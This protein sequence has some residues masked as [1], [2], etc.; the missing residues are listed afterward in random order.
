MFSLE[1]R[2]H[3]RLSR[4]A[5]VAGGTFGRRA[6]SGFAECRVSRVAKLAARDV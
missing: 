4:V 6:A 5:I 1:K 2:G 3:K